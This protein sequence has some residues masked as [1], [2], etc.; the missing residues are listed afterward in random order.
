M[1]DRT[2]KDNPQEQQPSKGVSRRDVVRGSAVGAL[3]AALGVLKPETLTA[4]DLGNSGLV[5]RVSGLRG[6]ISRLFDELGHNQGLRHTFIDQPMTVMLQRVF[7]DRA[8][9]V[10]AQE[11]SRANR[12]LFSVLAN[13][14]FRVWADGYQSDLLA[15]M[16]RTGTRPEDLDRMRIL[17]DTANAMME[18]GDADIVRPLLES[19]ASLEADQ[20]QDIIAVETAIVVVFVAVLTV[21]ISQIDVTPVISPEDGPVA[22]SM[23]TSDIRNLADQLVRQ[24]EQVKSR[25]VT[26]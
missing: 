6:R 3:A 17:T 22:T 12:F 16:T 25:R 1:S 19:S 8:G 20:E 7:P 4:A 11:I 21:F 14:Q 2:D 13:D 9:K 24:A 18:F 15:E 23:S 10:P 5:L 26:P